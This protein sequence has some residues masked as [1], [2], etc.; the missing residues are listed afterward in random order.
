[1]IY[2]IPKSNGY[3]ILGNMSVWKD[4]KCIHDCPTKPVTVELCG[5]SVTKMPAWLLCIAK[6][7]YVDEFDVEHL[8]FKHLSSSRSNFPWFAWYDTPKIVFDTFRIIPSYPEIAV[9]EHGSVIDSRSGNPLKTIASKDGHSYVQAIANETK[10]HYLVGVHRLVAMAWVQNDDPEHKQVVNH[11][12]GGTVPLDNSASNL[13]WTT[14]KGNAVHA[15]HAGLLPSAKPCKIRSIKTGEVKIFPSMSEMCEFLGF[16]VVKEFNYF[17]IRR[18]NKLLNDEWE[19]RIDGDDRPW[20]YAQNC[21]NVEPGRFIIRV[22]EPNQETKVFNGLRTLIRYYKL[23]NMGGTS[24]KRAVNRLL[25][26]HPDYKVEV[27]D[28]YDLRPIQVKDLETGEVREYSSNKA[29]HEATGWCKTAVLDAIGYAGKRKLYDR[30]VLRRKTDK[31]WPKDIRVTQNRPVE[32]KLI[33][34]RTNKVTMCKSLREASRILGM[35]RSLIKRMISDPK[36]HDEY[37]IETAASPSD[38]CTRRK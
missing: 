3:G 2:V 23:W 14:Y 18:S 22:T 11:L 9:D 20:I 36:K 17:K 10:R 6:I 32:L 7:G 16:K 29:L 30:Y 24:C 33:H 25:H 27:E 12:N 8:H 1:M 21:M 19:V 26:D 13:E 37:L 5:K 34:K 31:P 28:Q 35:D 38:R 15:V 4:G